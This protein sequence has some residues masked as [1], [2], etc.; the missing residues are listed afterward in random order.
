MTLDELIGDYEAD[1]LQIDWDTLAPKE[2]L[3]LYLNAKEF[4]KAKMQ[5]TSINPNDSKLPNDIYHDES[6]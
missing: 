2:R 5:R 3:A 1:K 6:I 4:F